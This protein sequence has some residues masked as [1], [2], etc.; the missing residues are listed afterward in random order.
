MTIVTQLR[1]NNLFLSSRISIYE[2][3]FVMDN[4]LHYLIFI[5]DTILNSI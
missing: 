3:Y 1:L 5:I 4:I 2:F